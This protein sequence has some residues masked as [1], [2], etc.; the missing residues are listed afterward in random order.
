M[1][2]VKLREMIYLKQ[3]IS[4][5]LVIVI[6]AGLNSPKIYSEVAKEDKI[7][8]LTQMELLAG[9]LTQTTEKWDKT[10]P[11]N[12]YDNDYYIELKTFFKPYKNHQAVKLAN[13][14]IKEN[15]FTYDAIPR[16]A[17]QL[18]ELPS[19]K[20]VNGY[21]LD[22]KNRTGDLKRLEAFRVAM[23]ELAIKSK[24]KRNF[25]DKHKDFYEEYISIVKASLSTSV[26]QSVEELFGYKGYNN[27]LVLACGLKSAGLGYSAMNT[28]SKGVVTVYSTL[29]P[30]IQAGHLKFLVD[31]TLLIH[32]FAHAYVNPLTA[33]HAQQITSLNI[34]RLYEPVKEVLAEQAYVGVDSFINESI[35]YGVMAYFRKKEEHV[36]FSNFVKKKESTGFYLTSF[37][38]RQLEDYE[39]NRD[40]YPSFDD[41][42]PVLLQRMS[43]VL[44]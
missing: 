36:L 9:V 12:G 2:L 39:A 27:I 29:I 1:S 33:K 24:F 4:L 26:S 10:L 43:E 14:L 8:V 44:I 5:L 15:R 28:N 37:I 7:V 18:S 34:N 40:I 38:V 21:G 17:T 25:Y 13:Q 20:A 16:F 23:L 6:L 41:F 35:L 30:S 19:L 11:A 31:E 42:Y 3:T 32:E 22:L